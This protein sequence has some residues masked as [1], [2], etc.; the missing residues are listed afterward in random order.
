[1]MDDARRAYATLGLPF[2][3]SPAQL[4]RRYRVLVKTWHPDRFASDPAGQAA[5]CDRLTHINNAYRLLLRSRQASDGAGTP[6]PG[7]A[8]NATA[9]PSPS[10]RLSREQIDAMVRAIG[11]ESP[12]DWLLG[13]FERFAWPSGPARFTDARPVSIAVGVVLVL[14][15]AV[16]DLSSGRWAY[17]LFLGLAIGAA[18]FSRLHRSWA[19]GRCGRR[20]SGHRRGSDA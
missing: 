4:K 7:P 20:T 10:T 16:I 9:R 13:S 2:G 15:V 12:V 6:T 18:G 3:A 17:P 14:I 5:A 8:R 1:M 11:T 19:F